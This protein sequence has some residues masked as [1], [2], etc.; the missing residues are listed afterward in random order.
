MLLSAGS[1][2][3][4]KAIF[5]WLNNI[6]TL[7][8]VLLENAYFVNILHET[9]EW[10]EEFSWFVA[11]I[12]SKSSYRSLHVNIG[13][14]CSYFVRSILSESKNQ[15]F[16]RT[17]PVNIVTT[18][19]QSM[20]LSITIEPSDQGGVSLMSRRVILQK[21]RRQCSVEVAQSEKRTF[22]LS[23]VSLCVCF[24]QFFCH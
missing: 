19:R 21:T 20:T 15:F 2:V 16:L 1:H 18:T 6:L 3:A 8:H 17:P 5:Q 10:N 9:H 22:F 23:N 4:T 13:R 24:Y 11:I 14:N 12:K 7:N